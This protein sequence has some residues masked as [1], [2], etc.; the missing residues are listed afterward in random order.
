VNLSQNTN[1]NLREGFLICYEFIEPVIA[2]QLGCF[3]IITTI[4]LVRFSLPHYDA[5]EKFMSYNWEQ[6]YANINISGQYN[7]INLSF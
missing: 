6:I 2:I 1:I 7:L 5:R 3:F 4:W